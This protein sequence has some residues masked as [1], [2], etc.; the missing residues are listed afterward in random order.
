MLIKCSECGEQ[1]SDQ[2]EMCPHCGA[3]IE[4]DQRLYENK[5][6]ILNSV[7]TWK[8]ILFSASVLTLF[9]VV[10]YV[11]GRLILT[12]SARHGG[13]IH[14]VAFE[15][16][17]LMTVF[18]NIFFLVIGIVL[19]LAIW[20]ALHLSHAR[21]STRWTLGGSLFLGT[22]ATIL[23][24]WTLFALNYLPL[25]SSLFPELSS[26]FFSYAPS[27]LE[28]GIPLYLPEQW[29]LVP[30]FSSVFLICT[31]I[32]VVIRAAYLRIFGIE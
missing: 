30:V 6:D 7:R 15:E 18:G 23:S 10:L 1:I 8:I 14:D 4:R 17:I 29:W 11:A 2:A 19:F 9:D 5:K 28:H 3:P 20:R 25:P 16:R 27:F 31:F 26:L 24:T 13:S 12:S 32:A 22:I 21:M